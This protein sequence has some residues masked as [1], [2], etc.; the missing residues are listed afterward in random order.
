AADKAAADKAAADKQAAQ[1]SN[2]QQATT[3]SAPTG[4]SYANCT[5][6]RQDYPGGVARPG[7]VDHRSNGGHATYRPYYSSELYE[8]N[9]E[10]DRDGDGIACEA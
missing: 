8:E 2:Q 9:S 10:K 4:N 7:A 6:L 3:A 1:S 5:E